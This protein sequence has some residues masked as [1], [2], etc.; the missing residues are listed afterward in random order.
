MNR[1]ALASCLLDS[2]PLAPPGTLQVS[3]D[4]HLWSSPWS[5]RRR[6]GRPG[7]PA[8]PGLPPQPSRPWSPRLC[9]PGRRPRAA[10]RSRR[11]QTR[12]CRP[13]APPGA[14][15][16]NAWPLGLQ[17]APHLRRLPRVT[18]RPLKSVNMRSAGASSGESMQAVRKRSESIAVWTRA[19]GAPP[20]ARA[21]MRLWMAACCLSWLPEAA[22]GLGPGLIWQPQLTCIASILDSCSLSPRPVFSKIGLVI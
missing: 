17:A 7:R 11:A 19:C 16:G 10:A 20:G 22:E 2:K 9:A 18:T 6:P 1:E 14:R 13:A 21:E 15:P 12:C 8:S 4:R 3:A 5:R